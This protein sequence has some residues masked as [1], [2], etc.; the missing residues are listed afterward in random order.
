MARGKIRSLPTTEAGT[1]VLQWEDNG[2][3]RARVEEFTPEIR[4]RLAAHGLEQ[5][6]R[7]A[8]AG[9]DPAAGFAAASEVLAALQGG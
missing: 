2:T 8:S 1:I 3:L 4:L 6:L 7:D 5:K 9:K